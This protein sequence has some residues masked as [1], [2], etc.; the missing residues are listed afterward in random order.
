MI[1]HCAGKGLR[2]ANVSELFQPHSHGIVIKFDKP[3][4]LENA[5]KTN[6]PLHI[7]VLPSG[8]WG[9]ENKKCNFNAFIFKNDYF[10][11]NRK[12]RNL[13]HFPPLLTCADLQTCAGSY[14]KEFTSHKDF[15]LAPTH[16]LTGLQED[17]FVFCF[18]TSPTTAGGRYR[19]RPRWAH[20]KQIP[21]LKTLPLLCCIIKPRIILAPLW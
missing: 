8:D 15:R 16:T 5:F 3:K 6:C 7:S 9:E 12:E 13:Q 14:K 4:M 19:N 21:H 11:L 18:L 2:L 10:C 1:T 20:E 17:M